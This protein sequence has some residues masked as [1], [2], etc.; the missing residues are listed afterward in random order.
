MEQENPFHTN[1]LEN[2][3][4]GNGFA[5]AAVAFGNDGAFVGLDPFFP[6]FDNLDPN[7][8]GV[9]DMDGGQVFFEKLCLNGIDYGLGAVTQ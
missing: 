2:F 1:T 5:D 7:L 8:D 9:T 4:Y 6:T 3:P